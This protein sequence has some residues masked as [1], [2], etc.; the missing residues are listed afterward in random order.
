MRGRLI[1]VFFRF[2]IWVIFF[3]VSKRF[4]KLQNIFSGFGNCFKYFI[5]VFKKF[6]ELQEC[7]CK[8]FLKNSWPDWLNFWGE[9][10]NF[11]RKV[12][13]F[14]PKN[15]V[16]GVTCQFM[17]RNAQFQARFTKFSDRHAKFFAWFYKGP[18][19]NYIEMRKTEIFIRLS[20]KYVL[21]ITKIPKKGRKVNF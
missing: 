3:D 15:L 21:K 13:N 18:R 4:F 11:L 7:F 20:F 5:K 10:P 1:A 9:K 14:W 8:N 19:I 6:S 16:F 17:A 2:R 12:S